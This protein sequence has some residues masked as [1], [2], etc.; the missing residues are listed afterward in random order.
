MERPRLPQ[1][2]TSECRARAEDFLG[3]GD[4]DVDEPRAVAWALL[5]VAGELASIRRLLERR[6]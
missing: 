3:L 4:T 5:A 6:R 2:E 1:T